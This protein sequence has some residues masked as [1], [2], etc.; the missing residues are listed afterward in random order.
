MIDLDLSDP[1]FLQAFWTITVACVCSVSCALLGCFLLL[2]RMSMMGDAIGHGILPGIAFA[3]LLTGQLTSFTVLIGAMIFGVLT[4]VLAETLADTGTVSEDSG[5][6]VVY[7]S[8]FSLGVVMLSVFMRN[9]DLDINC[10]FMGA[11]VLVPITTDD[12]WGYEIPRAFPTMFTA[13]VLTIAFL[14]LFWKELK[15]VAFDS[16]LAQS[17]GF[18]PRV[19]NYLLIAL[20]AGTTVSAFEAVGLILVLAVLIAPAATAHLLTDRL[21]P[22]LLYA[23]AFALSASLLGFY[24][25]NAGEYALDISG[26]IAVVL[27][28][29]FVMVVLVAP[30]HGLIAKW[31]RHV[32]LSRRIA[33]EDIL[34]TLYRAEESGVPIY[35]LA[36]KEHGLPGWIIWIADRDLLKQ[37]LIV[38]DEKGRSML[39]DKGRRA[40]QYVVRSHRLWE[41]YAGAVLE[42]P[43]DHVH[44]AAALVEH[45]IGPELQD[46]LA[47][48]LQEPPTD[49]HGKSIPPK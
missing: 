30:R 22:M 25:H 41:T 12:Y 17:M 48:W 16:A 14:I 11:L 9:V 43:S 13:L 2:K 21:A 1:K 45:Y 5:L 31:F 42:I 29:Q 23:A 3:F 38:R 40:G 26:M 34:G 8:L 4:A 18:S 37:G 36:L 27:G 49:P 44:S 39:T 47:T 46:E 32:Q 10:V 20:V 7:T 35:S 24:F 28:V 33:S 19:V 15:I 6:G